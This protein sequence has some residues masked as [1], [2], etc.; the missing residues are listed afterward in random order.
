MWGAGGASGLS[1]GSSGQVAAAVLHAVKTAKPRPGNTKGGAHRLRASA[2]HDAE[3][4]TSIPQTD[5]LAGWGGGGEGRVACGWWLAACGQSR[6]RSMRWVVASGSIALGASAAC[7]L[8]LSAGTGNAGEEP[9]GLGGAAAAIKK[10]VEQQ[11]RRFPRAVCCL[12]LLL[13]LL[14]C[15]PIRHEA[16]AYGCSEPTLIYAT[17][18]TQ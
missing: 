17:L 7:M 11:R 6:V 12:S 5:I 3:A 1:V 2:T 16:A 15:P 8:L 4:P 13:L 9:P 10:H 18:V 14:R